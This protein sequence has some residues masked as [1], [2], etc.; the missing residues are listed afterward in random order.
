MMTTKRLLLVLVGL[1][2]CGPKI[3]PA[4]DAQDE[5]T[6]AA[7]FYDKKDYRHALEGFQRLIFTYP[8]SEYADDAQ[9]LLAKSYY[10]DKDYD[11]AALEFEFLI[12]NFA[13]SPYQEEA[14]LLE[15]TSFYRRTPAF[16]RDQTMTRKAVERLEEFLSTYHESKFEAEARKTLS[17]CRDK[18]ARKDLENGK[19]YLKIKEYA[20]AEI[21]LKSVIDNYPE[22]VWTRPA[23]FWLAESFFKRQRLDEARELYDELTKENDQWQEKAEKRIGQIDKK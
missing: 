6:R 17:E 14:A 22:T 10:Q 18:L 8:G 15:A 16:P 2:A 13:H 20:A 9:F 7:A 19:F 1:A 12:R 5:F 23:R 4:L 11:Q 21:Y 3:R